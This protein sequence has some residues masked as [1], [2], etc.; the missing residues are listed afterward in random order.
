MALTAA[1]K[2]KRYRAKV[3]QDPERKAELK[4]RHRLRYHLKK[5]TGQG[6]D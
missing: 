6:Y 3:K 4:R 2:Q 5:E 1:E